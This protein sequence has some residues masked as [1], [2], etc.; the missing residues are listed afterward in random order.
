MGHQTRVLV[1]RVVRN[2]QVIK[3]LRILLGEWKWQVRK[4][5]ESRMISPP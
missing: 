3:L 2:H 1:V 5:E 4:T